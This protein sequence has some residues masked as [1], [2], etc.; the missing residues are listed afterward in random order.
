MLRRQ[1]VCGVPLAWLGSACLTTRG[2]TVPTGQKAPDFVLQSHDGREV[3][4]DS[5]VARGPAV[6]VFYRGFW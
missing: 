4:L 2:P 3:S 5:I 1:V 6:V